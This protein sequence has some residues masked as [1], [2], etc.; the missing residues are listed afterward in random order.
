MKTT[1]QFKT[2]KAF[3]KMIKQIESQS[4]TELKGYEG[5]TWWGKTQLGQLVAGI[6][7][8]IIDQFEEMI[9]KK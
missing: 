1:K 2:V 8:D 5:L 7:K 6:D 4:L 3:V 9:S